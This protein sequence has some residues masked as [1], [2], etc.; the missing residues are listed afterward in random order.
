MSN[1]LDR[2]SFAVQPLEQPVAHR[3]WLERS[4]SKKAGSEKTAPKTDY[5]DI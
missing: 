5:I 2:A 4:L 3:V 1:L